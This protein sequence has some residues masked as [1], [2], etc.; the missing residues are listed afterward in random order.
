MLDVSGQH[1]VVELKPRVVL[2]EPGEGPMSRQHRKSR[3]VNRP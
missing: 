1:P 3:T 2:E